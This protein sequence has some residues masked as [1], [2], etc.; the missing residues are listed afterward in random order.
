[1]TSISEP[2]L[3]QSSSLIVSSSEEEL[4]NLEKKYSEKSSMMT[5]AK[6]LIN[7]MWTNF[8]VEDYIQ[9]EDVN[10]PVLEKQRKKPKEWVPRITV[11]EPFQ[12]TVREQKKKEENMKSKSDIELVHNCSRNKKRT[13]SVR[14]NSEPTQFLRSSFSPFIVI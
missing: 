8:S 6:E 10:L 9:H 7:N 11:P 4:P 12:M 3:S 1:M 14:K 5:Y 13:Q 2:D